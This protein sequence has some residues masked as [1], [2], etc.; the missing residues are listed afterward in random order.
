[1]P[2]GFA[3]RI[4]EDACG[5]LFHAL[6]D[7]APAITLTWPPARQPSLGTEGG[8][9]YTP[10]FQQQLMHMGDVERKWYLKQHEFTTS[11]QRCVVSSSRFF[12]A[13]QSKQ[14]GISRASHFSHNVSAKTQ[15]PH[16]EAMS[17]NAYHSSRPN[18]RISRCVS[19]CARIHLLTP[20]HPR[21]MLTE[22]RR[23]HSSLTTSV[24]N[25]STACACDIPRG[26]P[27]RLQNRWRRTNATR[28]ISSK[29]ATK[30]K[31]SRTLSSPNLTPGLS[32][33]KKKMRLFF[34]HDIFTTPYDDTGLAFP[35]SFRL[36]CHAKL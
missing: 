20:H 24:S 35:I 10:E 9:P 13:E 8:Q 28:P 26:V 1:M 25:K 17:T 11:V 30:S 2:D 33:C 18:F 15:T 19:R 34:P 4:I 16:I 21:H 3:Y 14:T 23:F 5:T 36:V 22:M 32:L 31:R 7:L 12:L 6:E 29:R 27:S